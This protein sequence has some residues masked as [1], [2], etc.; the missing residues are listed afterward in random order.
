[1]LLHTQ[2]M[3]RHTTTNPDNH[4]LELTTTHSQSCSQSHISSFIHKAKTPLHK[5][6]STQGPTSFPQS[7]KGLSPLCPLIGSGSKVCL[8][9]FSCPHSGIS[10]ICRDPLP[11]PPLQPRGPPLGAYRAVRKL[12]Q[13]LERSHCEVSTSA[14]PIQN[15]N[16]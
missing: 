12:Q 15:T 5:G 4:V 3:F 13:L 16:V 8:A 6:T 2:A 11:S 9:C 7:R 14:S 1:M 10:I